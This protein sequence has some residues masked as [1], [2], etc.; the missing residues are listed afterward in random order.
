MNAYT[1]PLP[2]ISALTKPFWDHARAGRLALQVCR[3]CGDLRFPPSPVCPACLSDDQAW[4]ITSGRG[5]LESW[6]EFHRAYWPAF[7]D[8][9]P[10]S[11]CLVR[12]YEGPVLV[13]NLVGSTGGEKLGAPVRVMFDKVTDEITLPK[14][15][16]A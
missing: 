2:K 7:N 5:T 15:R 4:R 14:F 10:Y 11:V 12:L 9:L 16:L 8:F 3:V 13:S 6:I 1:K